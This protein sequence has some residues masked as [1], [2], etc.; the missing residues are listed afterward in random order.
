MIY[1]VSCVFLGNR[2][3]VFFKKEPL[4]L[5]I[6]GSTFWGSANAEENG[7]PLWKRCKAKNRILQKISPKRIEEKAIIHLALREIEIFF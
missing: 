5:R 2:S 1:S 4:F 3:G 6:S 7:Y